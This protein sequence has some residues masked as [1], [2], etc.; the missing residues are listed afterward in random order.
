[1][2]ELGHGHKGYGLSLLIEALAQ[3]LGGFGY[4]DAPTTWGAAVPVLALAPAAFGPR[5]SRAKSTGPSRP[6]WPPSPG[7]AATR[8]ERPGQAA[9]RRKAEAERNGLTHYPGIAEDLRELAKRF[10]APMPTPS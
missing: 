7:P 9:L 3:G 1:M 8:S 2:G 5:T 4:I 6:A 10:D